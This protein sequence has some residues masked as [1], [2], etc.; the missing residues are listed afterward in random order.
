M[1]RRIATGLAFV[2]VCA[3]GCSTTT[4]PTKMEQPPAPQ[5]AQLTAELNATKAQVADLQRQAA[6]LKKQASVPTPAPMARGAAG[7]GDGRFLVIPQRVRPGDPLA[8]YLDIADT[9]ITIMTKDL[10]KTVAKLIGPAA[11]DFL[12]YT[13]PKDLAPGEYQVTF[14][15]SGGTFGEA[16]IWIDQQ[17][18][19]P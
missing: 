17:T 13:V 5:I 18:P 15:G 10:Q 3:P 14:H 2:F 8:I 11:H 16:V 1:M 4:A 12:V 19:T 7:R 6:S 9:E